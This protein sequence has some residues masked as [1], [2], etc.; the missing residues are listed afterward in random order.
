MSK[1]AEKA[2]E[3]VLALIPPTVFFF[4]T[5][6]LIA[7]VR[8]LMLKGSGLPASSL[9]QVALGALILGKAV[10][11]ADLLPAINRFPEKPLAYNVVWKTLIYVVA[12]LVL[13]YL[14]RLV[15]YWKAAGGFVAGNEKMLAEIIW[16]HFWAIQLIL[17]VLIFNYC[18]LHEFGRALG[19]KKLREMF[20]GASAGTAG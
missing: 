4:V 20:F 8:T 14:E 19:S 16:P 3:E 18:V 7:V 13:H 9:A 2:K 6:G 10:L 12:A 15:E 5:L 17:I 11:I 1:V